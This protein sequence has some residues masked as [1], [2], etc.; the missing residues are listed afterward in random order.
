MLLALVDGDKAAVEV[1]WDGLA[2]APP[3]LRVQLRLAGER[4]LRFEVYDA[5]GCDAAGRA[6]LRRERAFVAEVHPMHLCDLADAE[7]GCATPLLSGGGSPTGYELRATLPEGWPPGFAPITRTIVDTLRRRAAAAMGA[8]SGPRPMT[9]V[10]V[11]SRA[12]DV[13]D[14]V[15][16][17]YLDMQ[18]RCG[19]TRF[20]S[21]CRGVGKCSNSSFRP[22]PRHRSGLSGRVRRARRAGRGLGCGA[23]ATVLGV[24]GTSAAG[25]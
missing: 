23:R 4:Q 9:S 14:R 2:P 3:P 6:A 15:Q 13:V 10:D 1:T 7:A 18:V 16:R 12:T 11:A 20:E 21:H 24:G 17:A 22:L 5:S 19:R 8:G 25:V